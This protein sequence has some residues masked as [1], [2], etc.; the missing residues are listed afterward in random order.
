MKGSDYSNSTYYIIRCKNKE[1]TDTY[2]GLTTDFTNR[3]SVHKHDCNDETKNKN[4]LY[5]CINENGGWDNWEMIKLE[6]YSCSNLIEARLRE[7]HWITEMK[8]TLNSNK[9]IMIKG[10]EVLQLAENLTIKE[11]RIAQSQFRRECMK[12]G[13]DNSVILKEENIKLIEQNK[14]LLIE[15]ESYKNEIESYKKLKEENKKLKELLNIYLNESLSL[16][17]N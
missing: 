17:E 6:K 10:T 3:K 16:N 12:Q 5:K 1:I 7:H 8:S 15:I 4:K 2:V 14:N 9:P 11:R 13:Y